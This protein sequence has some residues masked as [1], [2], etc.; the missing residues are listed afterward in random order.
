MK[1][2]GLIIAALLVAG[3]A[4]ATEVKLGFV[5]V[6]KAIE[7]TKA[8]KKVKSDLDADFKKREKDLQKRA[9][10]VKKMQ[11][12]YEKKSLVLSD[13]AKAKKQNE[14]QE[15]MMKYNQEVQKNTADLRK[16]E[17]DLMEPIFKKMQDVIN[18][19]A[20]KE[21]YT[22]IIQNRENILYAAQEIDLTDR[23][24]KEFEKK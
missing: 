8:G 2:L 9:D 23:V 18:D 22:L 15:E 16:K 20:K 3:T 10:D 14:L 6:R 19:I 1:K 17:Q 24:V 13:E 7:D 21:N 4:S 5:D 12:D 11:A